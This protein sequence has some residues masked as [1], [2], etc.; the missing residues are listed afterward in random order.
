MTSFLDLTHGNLPIN[1]AGLSV[2]DCDRYN[3]LA[4]NVQPR[5]YLAK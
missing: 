1:I 5:N 4:F 2:I 3:L